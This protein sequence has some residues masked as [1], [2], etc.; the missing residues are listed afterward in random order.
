MNPSVAIFRLPYAAV[1][2][3]VSRVIGISAKVFPVGGVRQ[4]Q[5]QQGAVLKFIV[6]RLFQDI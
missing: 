4:G 6:N 2:E 3:A 1:C 5:L